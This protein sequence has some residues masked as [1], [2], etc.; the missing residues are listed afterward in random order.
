MVGV[1]RSGW[2]GIHFQIRLVPTGQTVAVK[3]IQVHGKNELV[4]AA[5]RVGL[6]AGR[7]RGHAGAVRRFPDLLFETA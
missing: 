4:A 2:A 6:I 3:E 7:C 1:R 5:S